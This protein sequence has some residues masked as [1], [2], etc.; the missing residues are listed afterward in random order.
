MQ[1]DDPATAYLGRA[2]AALQQ[3]DEE[4]ARRE[5]L[6]S[7]ERAPFYRPAQQLLLRLSAGE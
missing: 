7:L 4:K 3:N 5:V 6:Y 2:R 1:V